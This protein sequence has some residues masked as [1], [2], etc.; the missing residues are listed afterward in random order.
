MNLHYELESSTWQRNSLRFAAREVWTPTDRLQCSGKH[1]CLALPPF[2]HQH[3]STELCP[4]WWRGLEGGTATEL[5]W[6]V[7]WEAGCDQPRGLGMETQRRLLVHEEHLGVRARHAR[8]LG[9]ART[10]SCSQKRP[11]LQGLC[12]W[13]PRPSSSSDHT[14]PHPTPPQARELLHPGAFCTWAWHPPCFHL[15]WCLLSSSIALS[16]DSTLASPQP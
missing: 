11:T 12:G 2:P 5:C 8:S 13:P 14:T 9:S 15:T 6:L 3:L 4:C 1:V 10:G 7:C 16:S